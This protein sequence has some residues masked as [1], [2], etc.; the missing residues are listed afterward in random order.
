MIFIEFSSFTCARVKW[1][2]RFPARLSRMDRPP[3]RPSQLSATAARA[4][5]APLPTTTTR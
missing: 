4:A 5:C 3:R 2:G 1:G